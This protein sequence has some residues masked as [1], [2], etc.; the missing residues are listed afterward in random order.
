MVADIARYVRNCHLCSMTK[1][2]RE[3]YQGVL[4]PLP[5]PE[6]RG[7]YLSIDF[8]VDLPSC[9]YRGEIVKNILVIVDR[10]TKKKR[11]LPCT[12]MSAEAVADLF[13][14]NVWRYDG[15]PDSLVSDRGTN[16]VSAFFQH[17]CKRLGTETRPS[18]AFHPETDGQTEI[19][20]QWLEQYLRAYVDY[21]QEDWAKYIASAEFC[22][23]D[24]KSATTGITAFFAEKGFHLSVGIEDSPP[25]PEG[26]S[27]Y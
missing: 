13:Y 24:I 3:K 8:I 11:F 26:L 23:N 15:T 22:A 9:R 10:L 2:N 6:R 17:L 1:S 4:K 12:D 27:T 16:F 25:L 18:T 19:A 14:D 7:K 21:L 5:V 20:N